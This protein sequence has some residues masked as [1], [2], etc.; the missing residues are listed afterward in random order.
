M[1]ILVLGLFCLLLVLCV[2]LDISILYALVAGLILFL[3]YGKRKGFSWYE[4]KEMSV[5]GIKTVRNILISFLLIGMLTALW[6]C[7]GTISSI[8][9]YATLVIRP[10]VFLVMC[11]LLNCLVSLRLL[12]CFSQGFFELML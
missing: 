3:V 4:L 12:R 11:F 5:F 10:S 8:V 7:A 1:D 2:G 6:R 9:C